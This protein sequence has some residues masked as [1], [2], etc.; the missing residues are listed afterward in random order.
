MTIVLPNSFTDWA[1]AATEISNELGQVGIKV[2]LDEP[3]YAQYS[4]TTQAGTFN[5]AIGG[6]GG[7][8]IPYNDFNLR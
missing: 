3:Q 6:F 8:G 2:N 1:A 4:Q 7:T 5:A